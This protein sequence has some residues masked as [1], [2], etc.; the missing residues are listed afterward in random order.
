MTQNQRIGNYIIEKEIGSGTF[1]TVWRGHHY[2]THQLVAIKIITKES[3]MDLRGKTRFTREISI[4]KRVTH[5]NIIGLLEIYEDTKNFYLIMEFAEKGTLL[6]Y[7]NN[8]GKLTEDEARKF[9]IQIISGLDYLH[10]ELNVVHRDIKCENILLD[11]KLNAKIIDFGLSNN[12][13]ENSAS[14]N[15]TCGSPA[16]APPEMLQGQSY[17]VKTDI[18]SSAILLYAIT[19]G[20]LPFNHRDINQLQ[21]K[22]LYTPVQYPEHLSKNLI[23]LLKHMLSKN[24]YL[25]YNLEEVKNHPWMN[26]EFDHHEED[27]NLTL[28]FSKYSR[29]S[30]PLLK[31]I[32]LTEQ[33]KRGMN[34]TNQLLIT[35]PLR[36]SIKNPN[37]KSRKLSLFNI[38]PNT[39][40]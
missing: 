5:P 4:L 29:P 39:P 24:P 36:N 34:N 22:I 37:L 6:D 8:N 9:F 40:F 33:A 26:N 28:T 19:V 38:P 16:Y 18:W 15:T 32:T 23:D 35:N 3:I 21:Q 13:D 17:T 11:K 27:T 25:R 14:F 2:Q 7:V 31:P 10:T 1:A 12:F 20:Y 30:A